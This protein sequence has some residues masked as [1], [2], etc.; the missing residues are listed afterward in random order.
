MAARKPKHK[1]PLGA[2][3][4]RVL[5]IGDEGLVFYAVEKKKAIRVLSLPWSAEN[6]EQQVTTALTDEFKGPVV[7]LFDAVE[8]HYRR[9]KLPK[10]GAFD[11][12]KVLQRKLNI[13][14]PNFNIVSALEIKDNASKGFTL[15][16]SDVKPPEYLFSALPRSE[17]LDRIISIL[18][19][20]GVDVVGLGLLPV[21]SVGLVEG[22]AQRCC[23]QAG[24]ERSKWSILIGHHETG[25]IRQIVVKDESLALTR[26][27][28]VSE[29]AMSSGLSGEIIKEFQATLSYITRYGYQPND[30]LD[31]VV[32]ADKD[33]HNAIKVSNLPVSNLFCLDL[34]QAVN[35]LG[36]QYIGQTASTYADSL[37]ALWVAKKFKID[38][39]MQVPA[40][41]NI[42]KPR[43]VAKTATA[44]SV[45][46]ALAL[47]WFL[48]Q[49]FT[50]YADV[51]SQIEDKMTQRNALE[52]EYHQESKIFDQLPIK[53]AVVNGTLG[54]KN[55]L[56]KNSID[57][58]P[59]FEKIKPILGQGVLIDQMSITHSPSEGTV[60]ANAETVV[61][62]QAR[63]QQFNAANLRRSSIS[64]DPVDPGE[65]EVRFEI[66]TLKNLELEERVTFA[67]GLLESFRV[68]FPEH[69]VELTRQFSDVERTGSFSGVLN[70]TS[71]TPAPNNAAGANQKD[72]A[73][74][75]IK[76]APL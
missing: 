6:F 61:A 28:P 68:A 8:Q 13:A 54:I 76:G 46:G 42:S 3:Y 9:D 29:A 25:G 71:E 18:Y 2:N 66:Y 58:T 62:S 23:D 39:P 48:F 32:I 75:M 11:K 60:L 70:S 43:M 15:T 30:G 47:G 59:V 7:L 20:A 14:F 1:S 33:S 26:L 24:S 69:T 55:M 52:R 38:M 4:R 65:M 45:V 10:V 72:T 37:H 74:F 34:P 50:A 35:M 36:G 73:E 44:L 19:E 5:L 53:P 64:K 67:E 21:E 56:E 12:S 17:N 51:R 31:V 40:L 27:T 63:P 22:L 16:S 57:L 41:T 49:S